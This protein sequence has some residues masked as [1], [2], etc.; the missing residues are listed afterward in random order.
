MKI[1]LFTIILAAF[2]LLAGSCKKDE[3]NI[4]DEP[5]PFVIT[6]HFVAGTLTQKSG[7]RYTSVFFIR[8]LEDN[9]ALFINSSA[10]NLTG[11]YTLSETELTFE[12]TG[13]NARIARFTLDKDKKITSAYYKALNTEYDATG[14]MLPVGETNQLAGK[15]FRG[16]EFKMGGV[17]NKPVMIYSFNNGATNSYGSGFDT[18]G[19]DNTLNTYTLIGGAGFKYVS[20]NNVEL[21]FVSGKRLT[22]FRS[23][24]LYYYGKYDQL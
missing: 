8:L 14:E 3:Q 21:G 9:K 17:S 20:G 1:K 18:N 24:G 5:E 10:T 6:D 13:G 22:V 19:I 4:P 7:T 23:A 12:V 2:T 16:E 15:S 11:T